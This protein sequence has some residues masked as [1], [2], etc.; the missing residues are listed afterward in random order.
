M[1]AARLQH[2]QAPY[3]SRAPGGLEALSNALF[4]GALIVFEGLAEDL[5]RLGRTVIEDVFGSD[6]P[7][8]CESRWPTQRYHQAA[9]TARARIAKSAEIDRAWGR[10]LETVGYPPQTLAKDRMRLRVVPSEDGVDGRFFRALPAHRDTWA[11]NIWAQVNWWTTLYP[12]SS[13]HTLVIWPDAFD[14]PVVNTSNRWNYE[15][16]MNGGDPT[17]PLLPEALDAPTGCAFPI[18]IEP[19]DLLA[20]SGAHLH[21]AV[22]DGS[23]LSRFGLDTRT[24]WDGDI[25]AG[26]CAPNVDG[27]AGPEHWSMFQRHT[28]DGVPTPARTLVP[29]EGVTP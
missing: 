3:P 29:Q 14:C 20:F 8:K 22:R 17:Y 23:G 6:E 25:A 15:H 27:A 2:W 4:S 10:A 13:S 16:L 18:V 21:A 1:A 26:R 19:G 28:D 11:S 5:C 7:A 9:R 12:L 24:V